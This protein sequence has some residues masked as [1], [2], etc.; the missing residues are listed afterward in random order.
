M[1]GFMLTMMMTKI[2]VSTL[3]D[4]F[5]VGSQDATIVIALAEDTAPS[6]ARYSLT[7]GRMSAHLS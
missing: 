2:T 4:K 1:S 7:G 6:V 3:N 5:Q